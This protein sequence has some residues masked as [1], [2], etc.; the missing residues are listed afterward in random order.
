MQTGGSCTLS[1]QRFEANSH[2]P[3]D[4]ARRA[5]GLRV[6]ARKVELV[7][8]APPSVFAARWA[9]VGTAC[10]NRRSV[11]TTRI[12]LA[13]RASLPARRPSFIVAR[14]KRAAPG[15]LDARAR[16]S[17]HSRLLENTLPLDERMPSHHCSCTPKSSRA[18]FICSAPKAFVSGSALFLADST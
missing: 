17:F 18:C 1:R 2:G 16:R 3:A 6:V 14:K 11:Q 5:L 10:E 4:S 13:L 9:R 7:G 15:L 12:E 8:P